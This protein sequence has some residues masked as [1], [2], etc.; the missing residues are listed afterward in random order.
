MSQQMFEVTTTRFHAATQAFAPLTN[1]V[2]D[3]TLVFCRAV[4]TVV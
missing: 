3:D 4:E 1:S 2:V